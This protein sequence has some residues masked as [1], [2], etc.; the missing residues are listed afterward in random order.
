[1]IKEAVAIGEFE[2]TLPIDDIL[3]LSLSREAGEH[4][5]FRIR[6]IASKE[7]AEAMIGD[8]EGTR[9]VALS[10]KKGEKERKP[11]FSGLL[12]NCAVHRRGDVHEVEA[13]AVGHT[14]LLDTERRTRSFQDAGMLHEALAK[15]VTEPYGD[16]DLI[17][18]CEDRPIGDMFIQYN[19]TDWEFL[20]R[21]ACNLS[22]GLIPADGHSGAR[23]Y[24]GLDGNGDVTDVGGGRLTIQ[25]DILSF[26]K[27]DKNN[28]DLR[29]PDGALRYTL[30]TGKWLDVGDPVKA[31]GRILYV[32][33]AKSE[34]EN[35]LLLHSYTLRDANGFLLPK[36]VNE[37]LAGVSLFGTVTGIS[38][39][40]VSVALD[41]DAQNKYCAGRLFPYSTV[42]SSPDGSG[43][44]VMPEEGDRVTLYLPHASEADAYVR[45]AVDTASAN[46]KKREVPDNKEIYTKYGKSIRLT[47][48]SVEI[49]SGNKLWIRLYEDSGLE[50]HSSKDIFFNAAGDISITGGSKLSVQGGEIKFAQ[51]SGAF[52]MGEDTVVMDGQEVKVGE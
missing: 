47:P 32:Y 15:A 38:K 8:T 9:T 10:L 5:R 19:E 21:V 42:Y 50:I 30:H 35:G 48:D 43:W 52:T 36:R 34:L 40:R 23:F 6:G 18:T 3:E 22:C 44:Y 1:M 25:R 26:L 41:I 51:G 33:S 45:S 20:K 16:A 39:D 12:T 29:E 2:V 24:I 4:S 17:L 7:A 28:P 11:R 31:D 49:Y 13:E 46:P 14:V 37:K 27:D